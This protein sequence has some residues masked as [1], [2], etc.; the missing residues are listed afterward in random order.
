LRAGFSR[1]Y[2]GSEMR[3]KEMAE[4]IVELNRRIV[5]FTGE[6]RMEI[7]NILLDMTSR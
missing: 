6:Q 2:W 5:D 7:L 4:R 1:H 3:K